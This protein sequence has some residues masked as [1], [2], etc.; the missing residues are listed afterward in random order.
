MV[1]FSGYFTDQHRCNV[2]NVSFVVITIRCFPHTWL[3]IGF[4]TR[5]TRRVTREEQEL[6]TFPE[7][8]RSSS[9]FSGV[10]VIGSFAFCVIF[11][12]S[13]FVLFLLTIVCLAYFNSRIKITPMVSSNLSSLDK[14]VAYMRNSSNIQS[15]LSGLKKDFCC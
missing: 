12:R 13:L 14:C 15:T 1:A 3:I 7:H 9:V 2:N 6:L 5:V 10:R 11:C 8:M 4:V